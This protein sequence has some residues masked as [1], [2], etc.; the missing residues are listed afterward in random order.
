MKRVYHTHNPGL[1]AVLHTYMRL[2]VLLLF[3]PNSM[4]DVHDAR[5]SLNSPVKHV[6]GL[7]PSPS[8]A[9]QHHGYSNA[10]VSVCSHNEWG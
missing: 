6:N 2:Q 4:T 1:A 9:Q 3:S 10:A 7:N 5:L 8:L